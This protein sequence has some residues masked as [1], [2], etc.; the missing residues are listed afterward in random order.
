MNGIANQTG[1]MEIRRST[2]KDF[3]RMM[4]IYQYARHFMAEHGNPNQ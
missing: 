1:E 4:E 3:E 2:E